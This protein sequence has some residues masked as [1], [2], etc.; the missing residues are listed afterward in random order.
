MALDTTLSTATGAPTSSLESEAGFSKGGASRGGYISS[1]SRSDA[2][3]LT[4]M[5]SRGAG[6]DA[7]GSADVSMAS[8]DLFSPDRMAGP[9]A[10]PLRSAAERP[11]DSPTRSISSTHS[12]RYDTSFGMDTSADEMDAIHVTLAAAT[13]TAIAAMRAAGSRFHQNMCRTREVV[14]AA[15]CAEVAAFDKPAALRVLHAVGEQC[16]PG[17]LRA[18][19]Q[20]Y[21]PQLSHP[22]H[23]E[24]QPLPVEVE[25][26][27][28]TENAA[29]LL[30]DLAL[31]LKVVDLTSGEGR[32][33]VLH[34]CL[35]LR[36]LAAGSDL[37]VDN[38]LLETASEGE[39]AVRVT[40]VWVL[41]EEAWLARRAPA[42]TRLL[43]LA[44]RARAAVARRAARSCMPATAVV[45]ALLP[46]S[47]HGR[48]TAVPGNRA[49]SSTAD[50]AAMRRV[51]RGAGLHVSRENAAQLLR[52]AA[53][54]SLTPALSTTDSCRAG[55]LAAWLA[56]LPTFEQVQ[57]RWQTWMRAVPS[58]V[59]ATQ[60]AF[61]GTPTIAPEEFGSIVM[62]TALP[63]SQGECLMMAQVMQ[64]DPGVHLVEVALLDGIARGRFPGLLEAALGLM[65]P[66]SV[67]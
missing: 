55:Q 33:D 18:W 63:T 50:V 41:A 28:S 56:P 65:A 10:G 53:W 1:P 49:L 44:S 57:R 66:A 22:P 23:H 47:E 16:S 7:P 51:L 62:Q 61:Y 37:R 30:S 59:D 43:R 64:R 2:G 31:E 46:P 34:L 35:L 39:P 26:C 52:L 11:P 12:H 32:A 4:P 14:N 42:G 27:M 45:L 19:L 36:L 13:P 60:A 24:L 6:R 48:A 25:L 58:I 3:A 17:P 5:P 38:V 40:D 9:G 54:G 20:G 21:C 67:N 8:S 15:L 29:L